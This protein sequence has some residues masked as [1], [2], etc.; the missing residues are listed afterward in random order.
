MKRQGE[1]KFDLHDFVLPITNQYSHVQT[2]YLF[3]SRRYRTGSLRS[4]IDVLLETTGHIRPGK[5][6]EIIT[7]IS[8]ALD[9]FILQHGTATS[10]VNGSSLT[11][12]D[13]PSLITRVDAE[14]IW[15]RINGFCDK[16]DNYIQVYRDDISFVMTEMPEEHVD[17]DAT[18]RR[19]LA[20]ERLPLSPIIG[21]NI[22]QA[23]DYI[24]RL[25]ERVVYDENIL[26]ATLKRQ[27]WIH[28]PSSEAELQDLLYLAFKPL[29]PDLNRE[30]VEAVIE[31]QRKKSDFN[32]MDGRI[33]IDVKY[34]SE[35]SDIT[36][37][38][39]DL[40]TLGDLY[41][42]NPRCQIVVFPVY[43][44]RGIIFDRAGFEKRLSSNNPDKCIITKIFE[45]RN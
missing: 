10:V 35:R 43:V 24:L 8:K 23:A 28:S 19:A 21:F 45:L 3:G 22:H 38:L 26:S 36:A 37:F 7:S 34:G 16:F 4:D 2:V 18:V 1:V 13:N 32:M 14:K 12:S 40:A 11:A 31:N 29:F 27:N 5:I 17:I 44:K 39:K 20:R 25:C 41:L 42:N 30:F 15:D 33:V 6:R 9:I